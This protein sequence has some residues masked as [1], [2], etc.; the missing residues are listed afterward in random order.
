MAMQRKGSG[1]GVTT[2]AFIAP[3]EE[4]GPTYLPPTEKVA[5]SAT[6]LPRFKSLGWVLTTVLVNLKDKML[7]FLLVSIES[8]H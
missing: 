5:F 3:L 8:N 7:N 1:G 6:F 4:A 2:T